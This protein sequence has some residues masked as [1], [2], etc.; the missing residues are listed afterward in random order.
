LAIPDVNK[1][2]HHSEV[3][4]LNMSD[5]SSTTK[6]DQNNIFDNYEFGYT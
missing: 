4:L 2:D 3:G 6:C 5:L 1:N